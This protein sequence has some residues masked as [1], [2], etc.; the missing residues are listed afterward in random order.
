MLA[1]LAAGNPQ[2]LA[3]LLGNELQAAAVS[4]DPRC[5]ARCVPAWRRAPGRNR[6]RIRPTCAFLCSSATSAIDVGTQLSGAGVCRTVRVASGR[7]TVPES[8]QRP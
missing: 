2:Q 7:C 4:L 5:A 8:C 1:A 6:V 3:P